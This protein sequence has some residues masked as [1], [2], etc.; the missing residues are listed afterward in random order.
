MME[1]H[2]ANFKQLWFTT[3]PGTFGPHWFASKKPGYT[4]W[5]EKLRIDFE[6]PLMDFC[7]KQSSLTCSSTS[8]KSCF[9]PSKNFVSLLEQGYRDKGVSEQNPYL[10]E[11][12][13]IPFIA[14]CSSDSFKYSLKNR[15]SKNHDLISLI[16]SK[17]SLCVFMDQ[18][19][20]NIQSMTDSDGSDVKDKVDSVAIEFALQI[21]FEMVPLID[22][23]ECERGENDNSCD[24]F[25]SNHA[26]QYKGE[27]RD[28]INELIE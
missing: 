10:I 22:L 8:I 23:G 17:I 7:H 12:G 2:A 27:L 4:S 18:M 15:L 6:T 11:F 19:A 24:N 3:A 28:K 20:R 14:P 26:N 5:F 21:L 9:N 16:H 13:T 1:R 25:F